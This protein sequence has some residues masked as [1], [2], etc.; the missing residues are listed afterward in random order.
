MFFNINCYIMD[1]SEKKIKIR[2]SDQESLEKF[3]K[4]L[5]N[6]YKTKKGKE[7]TDK[8]DIENLK[9]TF[10][11]NISKKTK[12]NI[13]NFNYN[14]LKDLI[15]VNVK[16]SGESRYY[17]FSIEGN[18]FENINENIN[19]NVNENVS[20]NVETNKILKTGYS[21]ICNKVYT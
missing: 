18:G 14:N 4:N 17:S 2:I 20:E 12:F 6:L 19:E 16:I 5:D 10:Y 8:R 21:L 11:L 7:V 13:N 3:I 1:V 15:G 9:D